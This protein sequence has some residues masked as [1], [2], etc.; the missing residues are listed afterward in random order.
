MASK[1]GSNASASLGCR[2]DALVKLAG[3]IAAVDLGRSGVWTDSTAGFDSGFRSG[4]LGTLC[5]ENA[6][7]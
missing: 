4:G 5:V 7:L 6:R 3:C 1:P 2:N